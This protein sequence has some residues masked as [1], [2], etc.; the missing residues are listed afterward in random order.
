MLF[1]DT[2]SL[3]YVIK[4]EDVY[5]DLLEHRDMFDNSDYPKSSKFFFSENKKV[6][7]KFKD[8]AAGMVIIDFA[9]LKP[10]M[11]SYRTESK[12]N[13]TAKGVKK[14]VVKKDLKQQHYLD[15]LFKNQIMHHKMNTIR[16]DHHE[17]SSYQINKISLSCYD[18]KRY[19]LDDGISSLA[20]GHKKN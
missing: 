10:K 17:I 2:D 6:I 1:S 5:E 11:Y 12:N 4:T 3:C 8:E 19:I 13:K 7:G 14:Y 18:D 9:G 15:C 20:Y 16:S